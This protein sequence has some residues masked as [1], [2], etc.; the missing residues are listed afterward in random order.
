MKVKKITITGLHKV[1]NATYEFNNDVTYFIG[2]NGVGKSTI[3]EGLQLAILGYIPGYAKTNESIMKHASGPVMA[4]VAELEG[5]IKITRTWTRTGQSVSSSLS[6]EG[7]PADELDNLVKGIELP[8]FNFN[9]FKSMTSNK[10]KEWFINFLPEDEEELDLMQQLSNEVSSRGLPYEDLLEEVDTYCKETG[11]T[12]IELVKS[13][14]SYIKDR[15]SLTK[16]RKDSLQGT[17][18]SLVRYDLSVSED[19]DDIK[20][21]IKKLESLYRQ[22]IEYNSKKAMIEANK[23]RAVSYRNKLPAESFD[24]DPRVEQYNDKIKQLEKEQDVLS[25]DYNDIQSALYELTTKRR[26]I[27]STRATCPYT[28]EKCETAAQLTDKF[29]KEAEELDKQIKFKKEEER[30]CNPLKLQSIAKDIQDGHRMIDQIKNEYITADRLEE[31]V[32]DIGEP[33]CAVS[34]EEIREQMNRKTDLLVKV[35]ANKRYDNLSEKV[36]SDKFKADNEIE[37]LKMWDKLTGP[38]GL[39]STMMDKPFENL[40]EEMSGYL[41]KMFSKPTKAQFNLVSKANSFS[42]GLLRDDHYIE[43]DYLSSGERCLFTLALILC[44]LDKSQS[45]LRVL[46]IDDIL[47]HL[48]D[49]N[50]ESL[51]NSIKELK[52]VQLILAGVKSVSDKLSSICKS[53]I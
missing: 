49:E 39:Q 14:N 35:E 32:Q 33:P 47:D 17:L 1:A 44:I 31:A 45:E 42:F 50:A 7:F 30:E 12:G 28:N 40:A 3:L 24:K 37:I 11:L 53:V 29:I 27:P 18:D 48:D 10:L 8:I 51:F 19:E 36:T 25:Q 26:A 15:L 9:E 52:N 16:G 13:L 22:V 38:N 34:A 4:V 23:E 21:E 46:L 20:A 43:F 5:G 2:P 6:V 41:T